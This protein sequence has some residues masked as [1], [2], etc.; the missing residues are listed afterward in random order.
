MANPKIHVGFHAPLNDGDSPAETV[1]CR[2]TEP[3]NCAR[4]SIEGKCAYVRPDG[5][6]K[7]PPNTWAGQ[8][9]KLKDRERTG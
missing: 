2:H 9:Q 5:V 4:H 3:N 8:F 6:C 7:T 1:G